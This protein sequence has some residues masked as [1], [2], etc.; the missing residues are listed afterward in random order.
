[1]RVHHQILSSLFTVLIVCSTMLWVSSASPLW[2][3]STNTGTIAGTVTDTTNAVVNTATVTLTDTATKNARSA[4]TN[5]AGRYIFVDVAPGTYELTVGKQGFS[6]SKT[7]VT[8][9]VG[10]STT[11]NLTLQVGG[12]NVVV[13][14][15][16]AGNELQTMNATVGN[17]ITSAALDA[18]P[19]IGRD[20]SSFVELQPGVS[21][22]GSV[23][24]TV[25]DQSYFSL[26]GGNNSNDMDGN[27][28][29]YTTTYAG[30]PTGGVAAQNTFYLTGQPT[31]V[32]PTPQDS[33]E[34]FKVNT[35]G[36]TADFN[37]SS[38]AEVKVVTKR[39]TNS[40][41]GTAYDYYLDNNWS[42]NSWQSAHNLPSFHYNR[43]GG[44][45][46]GPLIPKE[47]L[48]G[49]TYFFFN[50]EGFRWPDNSVSINR[51]VPSPRMRVGLLT[52]ATSGTVYNL[53]PTAVTDPVTGKSVPGSN[54]C[55][56]FT[57][58]SGL[59]DP[60]SIGLN[61]LVGQLWQKYEPPS[62]FNCI[63]ATI[64]DNVNVLGFTSNVKL[65]QKT[66]FMVGR[67]DHDFSQKWHF[68]SSYR[69]FKFGLNA[70]SDQVDIGG[71]F[72]GD[73]LGVPSSQSS[74][75]QQAWYLV[76]GLTT[77]ISP[78]VTNDFHYSFL[79]NWWQWGRVGDVPQLAGL[80]GALELGN[81]ESHFENLG[82]YNVNT[83]QSR[84][85]FWDGHD[86][87]FR[88]D[89]SMLKG[90]HLFQFGGQ[91]QHNF[92]WHQR[93]DNGA[94]IN[95]QPVYQMGLGAN[96]SGMASPL[97]MCDPTIN[98]GVSITNCDALT[99]AMLGVVSISQ[100]A[101]TRSGSTLQLNPPLTPAFDQS[102]IPY[103]NVYFSD[104]WH[105]K[106]TFT[107]TYGLGWTLEM[108]PVE[109]NGK[110]VEFVD[111]ANQ[112]IDTESYLK[113]REKAALQGG[114]YNPEV[115]FNLVGNT[116]SGRKYPYDPY[117]GEF[118][119]RVAAAWNPRF[120]SDS[121][122]GKVFGHEDTVVR[123]GYGR[124]YGRLNGVDLVL[125]PLLGTG[126]I[127]PVQ[128]FNNQSLNPSG[129]GA[130]GTCSAN[131][132]T[133]NNAFRIGTDGLSAPI[134]KADPTLPQPDFPG[135]NAIAAGAGEALDPHFRPNVVDSFDFT[136]QRQLSRK[137]TL[138][139]GYIGRRI[140]HEYQPVNINAVPYM[141]TLGGQRFDKAY[142]NVVLQYCGGF[143]GMA[144]GHCAAN[145]G[146]VTPQPF[147]ET[148]L[149]G[150]GY[151]TPGT[152][153]KTMVANEGGNLAAQQVWSL[154]SD[155]DKGAFNFPRSMMNTPF[156]CPT[157]AEFGCGGQLSSGV[158]INAS[159]GHG[160]YNAGFVSL[161]MADWKGMTMQSNFTWS[162]ALG[163]GALVQATSGY[164]P[165]DPFNLNQMYGRQFYDRKFIY[166]TF[167][168]YS[169]PFYKGQ[170]GLLGRAL[171]G[172]TFSTVF[173]TGSGQPLQVWTSGFSGQE[174]G[175]MDAI[176]FNDTSTA[177]QMAPV[178]TGHA[179]SSST[180][181]NFPNI[182]KNP[183]QAFNSF[184]NPILGL[185]TRSTDFVT[186]L[187]YWNVDFSVR[188]NVRIAEQ[189]AM[190]FQAV[191]TDI[192]NHNQ[193]LDPLQP[194]G[195][196]SQSSFG[197]TGGSAQGVTGGNRTIQL[198]ARVRF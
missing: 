20:V 34:E 95:Y 103:Y 120:D 161:K 99:A 78:N 119:P 65:P 166:N 143:A 186:G 129:G 195:L 149:A 117:Y 61:S 54:G 107:L 59:C 5:E 16:A 57:S 147:F 169:P 110:Q 36:Q 187:P 152:C 136:I 28:S 193:W 194:W 53:N 63:N 90:N 8:V 157:G 188:K 55:T 44:A 15:T 131:A 114:V 19:S 128:C 77:N 116:E 192:F 145:A 171:G 84:T 173:T 133:F 113:S 159:V 48:G 164:S 175:G 197:V 2:A 89:L 37:S 82:P 101:Y 21:P 158:G 162:K 108:P 29:T 190:E 179:Y 74:D 155:L 66:N 182:F 151:C 80:G 168:V 102:T 100:I 76:T 146:A 32:M 45:I 3:Q 69:Y 139:F 111:Q 130:G 73:K 167:I 41:H 79:R 176:N 196:F 123:G 115:G 10:S 11:A 22:E 135:F 112:I 72:S 104:T 178:Q 105:M 153:T 9:Q 58:T 14:V 150:T 68:M 83:Q 13:E 25:N 49:K 91:Y 118:S 70:T 62:N 1:M 121:M 60:R 125:V 177:I 81:G 140:T 27:M 181:G 42:S 23:G 43:F 33:V 160:D 126:L 142:A 93:T 38:G 184:R 17:T 183:T 86:Q 26:D 12:S 185:D 141:M 122:L 31:G 98:K 170:Q 4:S 18:L 87:M 138:E 30:D 191:F 109:K 39:G 198:G 180:P 56:T 127:Q 174:F 6:T 7:Q 97:A 24:G 189:V 134:P 67:I 35:A 172:W 148:A 50:Y 64:C 40:F 96:G 75:P 51:D 144:G 46:G 106:P 52:D 154:W 85:R 92:N 132:V 137:L 94:G 47:V 71:F 88:D 124:V 165:D 163:T 156:N